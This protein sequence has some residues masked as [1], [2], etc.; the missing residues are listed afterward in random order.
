MR[1]GWLLVVLTACSGRSHSQVKSPPEALLAATP[2]SADAAYD[3]RNWAECAAQWMSIS[4]RASGEQRAGALYDAACCYA[5]DGRAETAV[6]TLEAALA[7]GY[8]DAEHVAEDSDL[9]SIR[10]HHPKWSVIEARV[11]TS[12]A[13]FEKSI[14][15]PALRRELVALAAKDQQAREENS[16]NVDTITREATARMKEIVA[17]YGWPGRSL[18]GSDGANAAWV[19]VQHADADVAFQRTC[20]EKMEAL[21]QTGEAARK[22]FAFLWD[23]VAVNEGRPQRYGTQLDGDDPLP[24]EDPAHVDAR[25]KEMGLST[26]AEYKELARKA[27]KIEKK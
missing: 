1:C 2:D 24:M 5:L 3:A 9:A 7:A 19:L 14:R 4:E 26:L 6:T 10:G 25:R 8:W 11:K 17:T 22:D 13:A 18:V 20:L 15:E 12:F 16:P 23:R 27:D 21:V